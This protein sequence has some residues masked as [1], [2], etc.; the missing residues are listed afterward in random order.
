MGYQ[1]EMSN[2][3]KVKEDKT[4]PWPCAADP[5]RTIEIFDDDVLTEDKDGT[6]TK[7]T[8]LCCIHIQIPKEDLIFEEGPTRFQML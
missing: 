3:Y 2:Y 7:H 4:Y 1:F 6:F 5:N 8:G